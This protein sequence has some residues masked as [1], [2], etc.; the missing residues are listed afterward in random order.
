MIL[1]DFVRAEE[2]LSSLVRQLDTTSRHMEQR[3]VQRGLM[4]HNTNGI[5]TDIQV[6]RQPLKTVSSSSSA[7]FPAISLGFTILGEVFA[8]VIVFLLQP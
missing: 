4:T 3:Q 7:M 8:Y 6:N 1:I 2:D 5:S